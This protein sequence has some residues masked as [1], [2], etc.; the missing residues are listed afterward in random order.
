MTQIASVTRAHA[1]RLRNEAT[2]QERMV[3]GK[4]REINRMLGTHFRRQ[5]PIGPYIADFVEFRRKI[6]VEIDGGQHGGVGDAVRDAWLVGQ[7]FRVLRFWNGD[8]GENLDGVA[9]VILDAVEGGDG[10]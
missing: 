10:V 5:A 6:V 4:L 1:R 7:G 8:V 3:W 9:Q 2:P